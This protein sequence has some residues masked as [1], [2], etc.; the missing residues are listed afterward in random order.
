M[1]IFATAI[2]L[3]TFLL[4]P[5]YSNSPHHRTAATAV[6]QSHR[7]AANGNHPMFLLEDTGTQNAKRVPNFQDDWDVSY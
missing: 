4:S 7:H 5:V 2:T 6:N 1:K 3:A